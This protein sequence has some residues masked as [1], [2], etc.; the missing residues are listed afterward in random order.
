L[1]LFINNLYCPLQ[2][3]Y[4]SQSVRAPGLAGSVLEEKLNRSSVPS[5]YCTK[6][7]DWQVVWLSLTA[8]SRPNCLLDE[9]DV[10]YNETT[11]RQAIL[12]LLLPPTTMICSVAFNTGFFERECSKIQLSAGRPE[13]EQVQLYIFRAHS[14]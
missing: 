14:A 13:I 6:T 1:H 7:S 11:N 3:L 8:A 12:S 4:I 2:S 9:L 5:F 10:S